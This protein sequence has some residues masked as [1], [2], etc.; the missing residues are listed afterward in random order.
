MALLKCP[1]CGHDVSEHALHCPN[2]GCIIDFIK[3]YYRKIEKENAKKER[4][5]LKETTPDIYSTLSGKAKEFIDSVEKDFI[6]YKVNF[7]LDK[8]HEFVG[9]RKEKKEK[10]L[11]YLSRHA[12]GDLFI[13]LHDSETDSNKAM[14]FRE[15]QLSNYIKQVENILFSMNADSSDLSSLE[16]EQESL[17]DKTEEQEPITAYVIEDTFSDTYFSGF[18]ITRQYESGGKDYNDEHG[19]F[20]EVNVPDFVMNI[21]NACF[22]F[23]IESAE[24]EL[25]KMKDS[26]KGLMIKEVQYIQ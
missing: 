21:K 22:F 7:F 20:I 3:E 4:A 6:K 11:A 15:T 24:K 8:R 12:N 2:C 16:I 26:I 25:G 9:F 14:L 10:L 19:S 13:H 5:R 18:H 23:S 1:E 17:V